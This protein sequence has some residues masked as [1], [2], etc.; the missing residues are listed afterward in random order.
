MSARELEDTVHACWLLARGTV[1]SRCSR[2]LILQ[3]TATWGGHLYMLKIAFQMYLSRPFRLISG[4]ILVGVSLSGKRKPLQIAET[5]LD[6]H[7]LK[8]NWH[9]W[10]LSHFSTY[11]P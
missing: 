10:G 4:L 8:S 1:R 9:V 2:F 7:F 6:D 11:I 5:D 3:V